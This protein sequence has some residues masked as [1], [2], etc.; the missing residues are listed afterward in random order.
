MTMHTLLPSGLVDRH[1]RGWLAIAEQ[2]AGVGWLR[3]I[4][5][6]AW[7]GDVLVG[8]GAVVLRVGDGWSLVG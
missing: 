1:A 6:S 7:D 3:W 5:G 4:R 8:S 2:F